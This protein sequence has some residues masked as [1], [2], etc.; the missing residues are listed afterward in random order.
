MQSKLA[1]KVFR[2]NTIVL[3]LVPLTLSTMEL[4]QYKK[5]KEQD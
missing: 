1:I 4:Q 5:L 2:I 3:G